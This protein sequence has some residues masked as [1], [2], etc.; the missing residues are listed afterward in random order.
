MF[1]LRVFTANTRL[2][3]QSY[4]LEGNG[5]VNDRICV[6]FLFKQF[7]TARYVFDLSVNS[8]FGKIIK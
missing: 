8:M 6:E 2:K 3:V 5:K 1:A 7:P 4:G